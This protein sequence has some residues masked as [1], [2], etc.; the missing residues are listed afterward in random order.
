VIGCEIY[1]K[2]LI[3]MHNTADKPA[4]SIFYA[5]ISFFMHKALYKPVAS[6]FYA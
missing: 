4:I 3:F 5:K 2:I 6:Q 1:V